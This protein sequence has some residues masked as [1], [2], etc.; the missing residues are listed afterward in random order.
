MATFEC[1][2]VELAIGS[3]GYRERNFID[4]FGK[5]RNEVTSSLWVYTIG[6]VKPARI[7]KAYEG[8]TIYYYLYKIHVLRLGRDLQNPFTEVDAKYWT[9]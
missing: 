7:Y 1:G 3:S 4:E 8:V 6:N 9:M 5:R 2:D